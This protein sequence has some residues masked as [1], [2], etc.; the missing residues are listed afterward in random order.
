MLK[1]GLC[2]YNVAY[3]VIIGTTPISGAGA[4]V[5]AQLPDERN[6]QVVFKICDPFAHK[7][8]K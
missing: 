7:W 6:K 8:N 1:Q 2:D 5:A 3:I 4:D